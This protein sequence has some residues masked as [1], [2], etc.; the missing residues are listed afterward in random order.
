MQI[1]FLIENNAFLTNFVASTVSLRPHRH[2]LTD[3]ATY[4]IL[5][6]QIPFLIENNAFLTNFVA[7]TVSLRP[8]RHNLT[9]MLLCGNLGYYSGFYN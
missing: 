9:I 3:Y 8:H 4:K 7:S 6:M 5:D 1:P 2:N